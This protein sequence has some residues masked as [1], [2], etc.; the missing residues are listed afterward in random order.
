MYVR[1]AE[2]GEVLG[3]AWER[4]GDGPEIFWTGAAPDGRANARRLHG[5]RAGV[6]LGA[7]YDALLRCASE[8]FL[9]PA[10]PVWCTTH[11]ESTVDRR[12]VALAVDRARRDGTTPTIRIRPTSKP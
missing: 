11:G 9:P 4:P 2:C 3:T 1:C 7:S 8:Q 5:R 12:A 6:W 10:L